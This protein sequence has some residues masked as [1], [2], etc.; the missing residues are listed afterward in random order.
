[1]RVPN[2]KNN[3]TIKKA[4]YSDIKSMLDLNY[5]IYPTEWHVSPEYV[6]KI[7]SKN[8]EVYNILD[9]EE[10]V[11]GIFSLFP[12]E[13]NI[14]EAILSG[15][16]EESEL[17]EH[18]L[19]YDKEKEVYLY[20][21]S[22]IVDIHDEER[23]SYAGQIIKGIPNELK[24]LEAKGITIREIGAIAISSD[25]EN[26]LPKI[27]FK[28]QQENLSIYNHHFPVFRATVRDVIKAIYTS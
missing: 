1:M 17:S 16:L 3:W 13:K 2:N 22:L 28:M 19:E 12:L 23:K 7:M 24:R 20:L 15:E 21:I 4:D 5:K 14:Y 10:G 11:K 25:G 8:P 6:H 18:I 9:T 27:G 26:V